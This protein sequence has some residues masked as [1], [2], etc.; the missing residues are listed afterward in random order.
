MHV[1]HE[2]R[3]VSLQRKVHLLPRRREPGQRKLESFVLFQR[4]PKRQ[5][6]FQC[7]RGVRTF[8]RKVVAA[9]KEGEK[10]LQCGSLW[11]T[12]G[13]QKYF[14][15]LASTVPVGLTAVFAEISAI[16]F[17]VYS[18]CS[19]ECGMM[20]TRVSSLFCFC[21]SFSK[22]YYSVDFSLPMFYR[23]KLK[24]GGMIFRRKSENTL[25]V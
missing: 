10:K 18:I 17:F 15:I 12:L 3:L 1:L 7:K 9:A 5:Q 6:Q 8:A 22:V 23:N 19:V 2:D 20:K 25:S 16:F 14:V 11:S 13:Q 4:R 24:K 21:F